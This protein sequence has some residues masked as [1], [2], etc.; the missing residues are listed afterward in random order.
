MAEAEKRKEVLKPQATT[1]TPTDMGFLELVNRRLD[2][3]REYRSAKHYKECCYLAKKWAQEWGGLRCGQ[4]T[5]EMIECLVRKRKKE[6]SA[7][8]ANKEIRYLRSTFNFGKKRSWVA[9]NPVDGMEFF[10]TD[11]IFRHVPTT[12]E[13]DA[14]IEEAM[15]DEWLLKRF[16]DTADY[17]RVLRETL[18]RMGEIN[19]LVWSDVHLGERYVVLYTRK[20]HGGLLPRKIPMTETLYKTLSRRYAER[21]LSKPWVFWNPRTGRS[22]RERKKFMRRLCD[23]AGVEY[24]RFHSVRHSGA[25][26][27]DN[28][29]VPTGAIQRILGHQD[30]RTTDIYLHSLDDSERKAMEVFERVRQESL[31]RSLTQPRSTDLDHAV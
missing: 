22:Y 18:G 19:R 24:F 8:T 28:H 13:I 2:H 30:R 1:Q 6:G 21:D 23:R 4:I 12:Q 7:A 10:P 27:M 20:V 11:K 16:P 3:V 9:G 26:F 25:S 5:A 29:N 31:T 14:V 15:A 17:L